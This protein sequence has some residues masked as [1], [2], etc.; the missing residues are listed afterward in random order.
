MDLSPAQLPASIRLGSIQQP[1]VQSGWHIWI[2]EMNER[3]G[4]GV[5]GGTT[6]SWLSIPIDEKAAPS[7]LRRS[8][9][10]QGWMQNYAVWLQNNGFPCARP[11]LTYTACGSKT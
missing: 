7:D 3:S 11:K 9:L 2:Y 6:D 8:C 5:A 10:L 1:M 4:L